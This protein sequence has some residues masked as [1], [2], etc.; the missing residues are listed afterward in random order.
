MVCFSEVCEI[1]KQ[2]HAENCAAKDRTTRP[3][4]ASI[5]NAPKRLTH[6]HSTH[7][8][9]LLRHCHTV[10]TD[11]RVPVIC[12]ESFAPMRAKVTHLW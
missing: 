4:T 8:V 1:D 9:G 11:V 2:S 6:Q 10:C 5:Y 7:V 12:K 3:S